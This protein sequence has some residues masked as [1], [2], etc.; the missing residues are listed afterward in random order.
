MTVRTPGSGTALTMRAR[1]PASIS[2][3]WQPTAKGPGTWP[4]AAAVFEELLTGQLRVLGPDHRGTLTS[5]SSLAV[6][7]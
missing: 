1:R 3:T 7:C 4:G 2:S 5:R 6:Q